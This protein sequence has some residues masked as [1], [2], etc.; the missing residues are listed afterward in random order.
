MEETEP[1]KGLRNVPGA[2]LIIIVSLNT[3]TTL[4][5]WWV[6]EIGYG[7]PQFIVRKTGVQKTY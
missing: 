3:L 6:Y 1:R 7:Y 2:E 5:P 4:S